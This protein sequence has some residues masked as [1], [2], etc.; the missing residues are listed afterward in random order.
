LSDLVQEFV[1]KLRDAW[2]KKLQQNV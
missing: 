1:E 2:V